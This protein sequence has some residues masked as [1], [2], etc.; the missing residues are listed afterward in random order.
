MNT[1]PNF[2]IDYGAIYQDS[3]EANGVLD[4]DAWD[5]PIHKF[6]G[7]RMPNGKMEKEPVYV[8]QEYPR[9]MY[10]QVGANK[11]VARIVKSDAEVAALGEGWEKTPAAFGYINA[12]S[13]E[14]HLALTGSDAAKPEVEDAVRAKRS[15]TRRVVA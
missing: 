11:L 8:H 6:F 14:E 10:S 12:P 9:L 1:Q 15:Y 7:K 4:S 3:Q 13:R 5:P 2:E